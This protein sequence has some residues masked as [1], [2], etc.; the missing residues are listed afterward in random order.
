MESSLFENNN[1][2]PNNDS[3][4]IKTLFHCWSDALRNF[5]TISGRTTKYEFWS[6]QTVSLLIFLILWC[7]AYI[8]DAQ[9][10]ICEIYGLYFIAPFLTSCVRRLHDCGKTGMFVWPLIFLLTFA[11]INIEYELTNTYL[12]IFL[13]LA[14]IS[15]LF[16]LLAAN[17]EKKEN[18]YGKV[19]N[20]A[21]FYNLFSV[22]FVR[23]MLFILVSTWLIFLILLF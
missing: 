23:F 15:Y 9:Q 11:L 21:D 4:E 18:N 12:T 14:Y 2:I 19:V 6:F 22:Y 3:E 7:F 17:G 5:A 16:P 8:F 13:L 20:E 1:Q 10:I